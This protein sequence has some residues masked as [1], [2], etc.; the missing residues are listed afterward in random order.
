MTYGINATLNT[1]S[2][3]Q[4]LLGITVEWKIKSEYLGCPFTTL[5]VELNP[6]QVGRDISVNDRIVDFN[7]EQLDC[8]MQYTL[9]VNAMITVIVDTV[10]KISKTDY[11]TSL[12]YSSKTKQ[13]IQ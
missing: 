12:F 1:A 7:N 10:T 11:G 8:N 3:G 9:R 4:F 13:S 5:R 6:G 2:D